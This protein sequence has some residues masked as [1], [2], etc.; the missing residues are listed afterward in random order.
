[1]GGPTHSVFSVYGALPVYDERLQLMCGAFFLAFS[2]VLKY[3]IVS[4]GTIHGD[5]PKEFITQEEGNVQTG[6]FTCWDVV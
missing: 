3:T 1:M 2:Q 6:C 5:S 4:N